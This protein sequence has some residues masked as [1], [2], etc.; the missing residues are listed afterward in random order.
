MT[1]FEV[2]SGQM[3]A[4]ANAV[5]ASAQ[6][7]GTEVDHMMRHLLD[8]Q[9]SWQGQAAASFQHLVGEWRDTQSRV[10]ATLEEVQLALAAAARQYEDVEH[11]A[12]R[13]FS[14]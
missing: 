13:L 12:T 6:Q 10:R 1:R 4:A 14:G 7:I 9:A 2:D 5:R 3:T 8:L 11:T